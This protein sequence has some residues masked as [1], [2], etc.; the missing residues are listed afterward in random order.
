MCVSSGWFL[1]CVCFSGGRSASGEDRKSASVEKRPQRRWEEGRFLSFSYQCSYLFSVYVLRGGN[2]PD[3]LQ[4]WFY[5]TSSFL[6]LCN[7]CLSQDWCVRGFVVQMPPQHQSS[8]SWILTVNVMITGSSHYWREWLRYT[9]ARTHART[10]TH[11]HTH[12]HTHTHTTL[13]YLH[14]KLHVNSIVSGPN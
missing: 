6:F 14:K 10:H 11:R 3:G 13:V 2:R 5:L 1:L 7:S 8:P 12:T 9:G 4:K